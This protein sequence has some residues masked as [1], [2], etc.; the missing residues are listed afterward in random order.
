METPTYRTCSK[1]HPALGTGAA[2]LDD[3]RLWLFSPGQSVVRTKRIY[4]AVYSCAMLYA[5][6]S[7][8]SVNREIKALKTS[9]EKDDLQEDHGR[10]RGFNA[11]AA[12]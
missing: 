7:C 10:V 9:T 8:V 1:W 5:C 11:D 3:G 6:I 4:I 2:R 12:L